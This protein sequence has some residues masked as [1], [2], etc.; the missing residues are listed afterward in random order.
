MIE[1]EFKASAT[2]TINVHVWG[3]AEDKEAAIQKSKELIYSGLYESKDLESD[4]V[5]NWVEFKDSEEDTD[6]HVC[7]F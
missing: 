1:R 7:E 6:T 4:P 5:I 3:S 2:I